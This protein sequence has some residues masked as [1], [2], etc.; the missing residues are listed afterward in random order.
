MVIASD[1]DLRPLADDLAPQPDPAP[2]PELQ[3]DA[4][5]V[6]DAMEAARQVRR[7][8]HHEERPGP[9]SDGEEPLEPLGGWRPAGRDSPAV[10]RIEHED[11]DRPGLEERPGHLHALRRVTRDEHHEPFEPDPPGDCLDRVQ[12]ARAVHP[13]GERPGGLG[14]G[15]G[16]EGKRGCPGRARAGDGDTPRSGQAG[17]PEKGVQLREPGGDD[18]TRGI[19]VTRRKR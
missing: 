16:P 15:D 3:A 4:N 17:R 18:P 11:I 13:G 1:P 9:S 19:R 5:P 14:G 6:E 2:A 7:L 12:A 8:E 10:A